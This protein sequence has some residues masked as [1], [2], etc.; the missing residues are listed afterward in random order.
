[1]EVVFTSKNMDN[2]GENGLKNDDLKTWGE[3]GFDDLIG[4][5]LHHNDLTFT[6]K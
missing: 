2:Y 6:N 4:K 5:N 3:L 1:M